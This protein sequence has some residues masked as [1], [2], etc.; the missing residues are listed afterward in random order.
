MI[1]SRF[2]SIAKCVLCHEERELS[3]SHVIPKMCFRAFRTE[4]GGAFAVRATNIREVVRRNQSGFVERLLCSQCEALLNDRYERP[5]DKYWYRGDILN[6]IRVTG[7]F[8]VL[9]DI[10]YAT[11]KLFHLSVLFRA[12]HASHAQFASIDLGPRHSERIRQALIRGVAPPPYEYPITAHAVQMRRNGP[13]SE[14][15]G[16]TFS[17]RFDGIITHFIPYAGCYWTFGV[18]SQR[19]KVIENI[20]LNENGELFVTIGPPLD[21]DWVIRNQR[22]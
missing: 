20:Q 5:F 16:L 7:N 2:G 4:N 15:V 19:S 8:D 14:Y 11:F 18:S 6:K 21:K 22:F 1:R 12:H 10:D 17:K 9:G 3:L 13:I